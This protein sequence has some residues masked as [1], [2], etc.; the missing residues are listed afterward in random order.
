MDFES[1][2]MYYLAAQGLF[3]SPQFSIRGASGGEW[4]CPD[5]VALDFS[6]H[7]VQVVEVTVASNVSGLLEKIQDRERQ[8]FQYLRQQLVQRGVIDGS[9]KLIVRAFVRQDQLEKVRSKFLNAEDVK[10]EP[11]EQVTFSWKWPWHEWTKA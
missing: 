6:K 9:W 5:F 1:V 4:S 8:W 3:L 10:V 2:V 11:I 7:E